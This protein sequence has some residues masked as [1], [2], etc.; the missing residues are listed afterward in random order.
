MR[1]PTQIHR[2]ASA[3]VSADV[4]VCFDDEAVEWRR[5][6][7]RMEIVIP[8]EGK[9]SFTRGVISSQPMDFPPDFRDVLLAS[10]FR[11]TAGRCF[12]LRLRSR[13]TATVW[14]VWRR[15]RTAC[16]T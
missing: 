4:V 16:C 11:L 15:R 8:A 7:R 9:L 12:G 14:T 10:G 3:A 5:L 2:P 1:Y 6:G 13:L